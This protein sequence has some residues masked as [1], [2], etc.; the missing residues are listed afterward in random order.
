MK[1]EDATFSR[2]A[3]PVRSVSL[4]PARTLAQ[5]GH[6]H[7]PAL[8]H[9]EPTPDQRSKASAFVKIV[10]ESTERFKDV[11]GG[12][13]GGL[14]LFNSAASAGSD[15]GAMGTPLCELPAGGRRRTGRD[16][17]PDRAFTS[18]SRTDACG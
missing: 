12:R 1:S 15:A 11:A 8:Q 10:R 17:S 4:W 5:D 16:A 13:G 3:R 18:R 2:P 9:H 6:A 7:A 14:W